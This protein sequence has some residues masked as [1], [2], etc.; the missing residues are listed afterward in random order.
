MSKTRAETF[1]GLVEAE[2]E[3][4]GLS[5]YALAG[6]SGVS[7]QH[8]RDVERDRREPSLEVARRLAHG[9]GVPLQFLVD[10]L[11]PLETGP[12]P[13]AKPRGR[14]PKA[15]ATPAPPA[16]PRPAARKPKA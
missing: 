2:R 6:R 3:R 11:P 15:A 8:V 9:L 12:P 14:P 16:K 5:A 10:R 13:P 4:Q 7:S 1:G